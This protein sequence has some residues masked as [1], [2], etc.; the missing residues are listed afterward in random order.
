MEKFQY[1]L[2]ALPL[3]NDVKIF[4]EGDWVTGWQWAARDHQFTSVTKS[5]GKINTI[6]EHSGHTVDTNYICM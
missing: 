2:F 6:F 4:E 5:V 1:G 3:D